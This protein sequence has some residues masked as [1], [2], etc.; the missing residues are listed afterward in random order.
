MNVEEFR[1]MHARFESPQA[2]L[3]H[4]LKEWGLNLGNKALI[5]AL[6]GKDQSV[7]NSKSEGLSEDDFV[8]CYSSLLQVLFERASQEL[9]L[10]FVR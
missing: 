4:E 10:L 3:A 2:A 6:S 5:S 7:L 8:A 1:M 9:S